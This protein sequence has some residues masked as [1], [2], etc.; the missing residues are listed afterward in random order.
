VRRYA[1]DFPI[2]PV[3]MGILLRAVRVRNLD[4]REAHATTRKQ[5]TAFT[6]KVT[7]PRDRENDHEKRPTSA[8]LP[9]VLR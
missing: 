1:S 4:Y 9:F 3:R 6:L 5:M 2:N 8:L 7:L